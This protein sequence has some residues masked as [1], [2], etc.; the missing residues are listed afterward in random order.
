MQ[1]IKRKKIIKV[2]GQGIEQKIKSKN[3]LPD[4][5]N[6]IISGPSGS[7]KS[8]LLYSLLTGE[9]N[10]NYKHLYVY[11]DTLH[12]QNYLLLKEILGDR[13]HGF[14]SDDEILLPDEAEPYS[15]IVFDDISRGNQKIIEEYYSLGRHYHIHKFYLRQSY[16]QIPKGIRDNC[17][18]L[19]LYELDSSNLY[20]VYSS[21]SIKKFMSF[22]DFKSM[23]Y[24]CWKNKYGYL[25]INKENNIFTNSGINDFI[26]SK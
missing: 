8:V 13:F 5:V 16:T 12:Q 4:I 21:G 1:Q 17:N 6:G 24:E 9:N 20:N 25:M 23:C 18:F 11:S 26:L 19:A 10:L 22:E 7:G 15:A 2:Y 14:S 3:L